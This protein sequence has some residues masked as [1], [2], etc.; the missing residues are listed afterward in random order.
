MCLFYAYGITAIMVLPRQWFCHDN[1]LALLLIF[2]TSLI[3]LPRFLFLP[4]FLFLLS[5]VN[6][7][8][9]MALLCFFL[10][11]RLLILLLLLIMKS[12]LIAID[13]EK[14]FH[15]SLRLHKLLISKL[16]HLQAHIRSLRST[17]WSCGRFIAPRN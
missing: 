13:N 7:L 1:G 14:C 16:T 17:R 12:D 8:L 15:S 11:L 4:C 10:L 5:L 9:L 6:L 2:F 3:A